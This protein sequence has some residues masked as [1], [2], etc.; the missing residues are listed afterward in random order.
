MGFDID[1]LRYQDWFYFVSTIAW[2]VL[3]V[4]G[5]LARLAGW[6]LIVS[7]GYSL[8]KNANRGENP[9]MRCAAMFIGGVILLQAEEVFRMA[10]PWLTGNATSSKMGDLDSWFAFGDVS[11]DVKTQFQD[12]FFNLAAVAGYTIFV[13]G[14]WKLARVGQPNNKGQPIRLGS[15][16][17]TVLGGILLVYLPTLVESV[18]A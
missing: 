6:C 7:A 4:V 12:I 9:Y 18:R 10:G 16:V 5:F 17:S 13:M 8:L 14:L 1:D 2:A 11:G 3:Q 15:A